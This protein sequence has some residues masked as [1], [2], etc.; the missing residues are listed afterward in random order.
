MEISCNSID[1][2]YNLIF[3]PTSKREQNN[4]F[5]VPST[6]LTLEI[7]NYE[8]SLMLQNLVDEKG[9]KGAKLLSI[10]KKYIRNCSYEKGSLT[11]ED[12][13]EILHEVVIK[14]IKN[15]KK[16][17]TNYGGWLFKVTRNECMNK[18]NKVISSK[19]IV[20]LLTDD[21]QIITIS[22]GVGGVNFDSKRI[23][24]YDCI[25]YVFSIAT[26]TGSGENDR[27]IF[28][29]Y[30]NGFSHKEIS[31]GLG[32][33]VDAIAKRIS[34]LNRRMRQLIDEYC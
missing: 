23:E 31:S 30:I 19:N 12:Q 4:C 11:I 1:Y 34:V 10:L 17:K 2:L 3:S 26:N 13:Q 21:N 32:R 16:I 7:N 24:D 18:L 8:Y 27:Y 22:E 28:M 20:E 15:H 9:D 29:Q 33:S 25:E 6:K 5:Q 14:I